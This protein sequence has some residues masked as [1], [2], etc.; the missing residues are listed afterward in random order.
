MKVLMINSVCGVGST[1]RICTDMAQILEKEGH[2]C[3]IAYGRAPVPERFQKDAIRIGSDLGVNVHAGLSRIFDSTAFHSKRATKKFIKRI[4]E[5]DPDVIHL[6][7]LHGYYIHLGILFDY[8]RSCGKRIIWTLHDCWAF[9]GHCAYFDIVGCEKW[10]TGCY[11]CPQKRGYPS[12]LLFDRSKKNYAAKKKLFSGIPNLTIVTPSQWLADLVQESFLQQYSVE[13]IHNG[14]DLSVFKPTESDFRKKYGL[15]NKTVVLGVANVW[16]SS[17]GFDDFIQ[18]STML[19]EKYKIVLVGVTEQQKSNLPENVIGISRTNSVQELAEIYTAA[20]VFV[21]PTK[22]DNYPTVNLEAQAC[23]TPVIT[24]RSGGSVE[25]VRKECVV[26]QNNIQRLKELIQSEEYKNTTIERG[27]FNKDDR[28]NEY[29][30]LYT[31]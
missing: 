18:L 19:D 9:T 2:D 16:V 13:V 21:N 26:E 27:L 29:I 5:Y 15:E 24:Y 17:K 4:K 23:G 31:R 10:K 3:K 28:F 8:L 20:D 30:R 11:A 22:Q 14:I 7:N 1:G 25:S 6:H 12:S